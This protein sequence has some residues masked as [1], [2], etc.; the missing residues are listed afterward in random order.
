MN[1]IVLYCISKISSLGLVHI[2]TRWYKIINRAKKNSEAEKTFNIVGNILSQI[3]SDF[4]QTIPILQNLNQ[5]AVQITIYPG[6]LS[7]QHKRAQAPTKIRQPHRCDRPR[8]QAPAKKKKNQSIQNRNKSNKTNQA[9]RYI[10]F[11][12]ETNLPCIG[13]R[14]TLCGREFHS[15][16]PK[17]T[18]D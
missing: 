1:C 9:L 5:V 12:A 13:N 2:G 6:P 10:P 17:T 7:T 16:Q 3:L 18:N 15:L 8:N 4:I 14:F 11:K